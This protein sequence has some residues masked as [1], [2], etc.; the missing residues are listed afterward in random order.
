MHRSIWDVV[1]ASPTTCLISGAQNQKQLLQMVGERKLLLKVI[2]RRRHRWFGEI[3]RKENSIAMAVEGKISGKTQRGRKRKCFIDELKELNDCNTYATLK[4]LFINATTWKERLP[5][6][7]TAIFHL[8]ILAG[9]PVLR[10]CTYYVC[11]IKIKTTG[12][13]Y[14]WQHVWIGHFNLEASS[15]EII[16]K[17]YIEHCNELWSTKLVIVSKLSSFFLSGY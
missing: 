9:S 3:M 13:V 17:W 16:V 10:T 11:F 7:W 5:V 12:P 1:L 15:G 6:L 2:Q 4:Q 14:V 8:C